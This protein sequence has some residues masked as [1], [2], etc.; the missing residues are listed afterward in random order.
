MNEMVNCPFC[1]SDKILC[2]GDGRSESGMVPNHR[3]YPDLTMA[4]MCCQK[5]L[6]QGPAV[7][8]RRGYTSKSARVRW[9]ERAANTKAEQMPLTRIEM[10]DG[11]P[12]RCYIET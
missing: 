10:I 11:K 6:A 7:Y 2:E 12:V 4:W 8:T 3:V 1:G 5:C 9:N